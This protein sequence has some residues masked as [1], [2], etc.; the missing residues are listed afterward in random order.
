MT[1][2]NRVEALG[3]VGTNI[4]DVIMNGSD[5]MDTYIADLHEGEE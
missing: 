5:D 3:K 2:Q 4:P 1:P